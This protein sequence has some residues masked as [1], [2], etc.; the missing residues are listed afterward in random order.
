MYITIVVTY[1]KELELQINCI[2]IFKK[3]ILN[4]E[5]IHEKK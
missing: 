3:S 1:F 2:K 4:R 5:K